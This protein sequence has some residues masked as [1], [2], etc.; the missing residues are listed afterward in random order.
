MHSFTSNKESVAMSTRLT[1]EEVIT[2]LRKRITALQQYG[3]NQAQFLLSG[4]PYTAAQLIPMYQKVV[5]GLLAVAGKR[6]ELHNL[7]VQLRLDEAAEHAI[8]KALQAWVVV[9]YG[10]NSQ[11]MTDFD[12]P[13]PKPRKVT[14][15]VMAQAVDKSLATRK[16]RHTAGTKQKAA[17][18]G[19]S[20]PP[21]PAKPAG[22]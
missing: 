20:P 9:T 7:V 22:Q 8:D 6:G 11:A 21:A 18:T 10:A 2:R 13:P 1:Q 14:A 15:K 3:Q 19:E 17:I 12:Y 5:D 16:A 4:K